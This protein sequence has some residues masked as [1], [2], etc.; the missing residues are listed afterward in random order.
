LLHFVVTVITARRV[1]MKISIVVPVHN[2]EVYLPYSLL[3]LKQIKNQVSEII[4]VLDN[5]TDKSECLIRAVLPDVTILTLRKHKWKYY[6]AES[7]QY[8]FNKASGYV[9]CAAGAD[10]VVDKELPSITQ[11]SFRDEKV[12]T[13]C[14]RYLNYD[15]F[16]PWLKFIGTYDNIYKRIIQHFRKEARHTGFYAFRRKM[17][18]E[19]GGLADIISEYD[20]FCRRTEKS[21]W[22]VRYIPQTTTLHLRPGLTPRKQ[23][24]QGVARAYLPDYN[25]AKTLLHS[26]I[27]IKPYLIV[28]YIHTKQKLRHNTYE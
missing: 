21:G 12:G 13:V 18:E 4:F 25:L 22:K 2:E 6:T 19:I 20:E 27:H 14:F 17:M 8:G 3:S 24:F 5:C 7:F 9:I 1:K 15:L 26:L 10:L 28:G 23:Y 16:S 11:E